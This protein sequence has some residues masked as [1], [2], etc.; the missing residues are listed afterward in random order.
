MADNAKLD[1]KRMEKVYSFVQKNLGLNKEQWDLYRE[2]MASIESRGGGDYMAIGGENNHYD[3]RYQLGKDAKLDGS[4]KYIGENKPRLLHD[5][6]SR[7]QFRNDP[8]L[9]EEMFAGYTY[10][11][12]TYMTDMKYAK[13]DT[14]MK[15]DPFRKLQYLSY[16]HNQGHGGVKKFMETGVD[17]KD[18]F[19]TKGT[20]YMRTLE[21]MRSKEGVSFNGEEI[22]TIEIVG[23][24]NGR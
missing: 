20:K 4:R 19:G 7:E 6:A 8:T 11:N 18:A 24:N 12:S 5:K 22:P 13:K 1:P 17:T 9:Q 23:G 16:A 21:N 2:A 10:A 3:G 15:S 14:Y